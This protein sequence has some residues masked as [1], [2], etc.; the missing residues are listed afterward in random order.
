MKLVVS[1][2]LTFVVASYKYS[3]A[4]YSEWPISP[5]RLVPR[6]SAVLRDAVGGLFSARVLPVEG[7]VREARAS[8]LHVSPPL[9]VSLCFKLDRRLR[10]DERHSLRLQRHCGSGARAL[11]IAAA[12][13]AG[14]KGLQSFRGPHAHRCAS[15]RTPAHRCGSRPIARLVR[16][17]RSRL[18]SRWY[19]SSI[20]FLFSF[21]F[22]CVLFTF[23]NLKTHLIKFLVTIQFNI[24]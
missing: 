8:D 18:S 7:L 13:A 10:F 16:P 12:A 23:M 21:S 3:R 4:P 1:H 9:L 19:L 5:G 20:I 6:G 15:R 17:A 2:A 14:R 22:L 11:S 24:L